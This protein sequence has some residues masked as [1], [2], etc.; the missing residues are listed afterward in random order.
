M[1]FKWEWEQ[2]VPVQIEGDM[3]KVLEEVSEMSGDI[4]RIFRIGRDQYPPYQMM[5]C[6]GCYI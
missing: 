5:W 1:D 4:L 3:R 6:G 2:S